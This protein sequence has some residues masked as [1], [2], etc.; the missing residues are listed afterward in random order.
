MKKVW[1]LFLRRRRLW[2]SI[3]PPLVTILTSSVT[4]G[5][6]QNGIRSSCVKLLPKPTRTARP[7][8]EKEP[9][10]RPAN[11]SPPTFTKF[12]KRN[13]IADFKSLQTDTGPSFFR[14]L[15][16]TG[17][18]V[19]A[20]ARETDGSSWSTSTSRLAMAELAFLSPTATAVQIHRA[21]ASAQ[22]AATSAFSSSMFFNA[23]KKASSKFAT[24][25]LGSL[26]LPPPLE[27]LLVRCVIGVEV[28]EVLGQ[29]PRA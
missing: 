6:V 16:C 1:S 18:A 19:A 22:A 25:A 21:N 9:P 17:V 4:V 8:S 7:P 20:A 27:I 11:A 14:E 13:K 10:A 28:A 29:C 5:N 3:R 23:I 26:V 2:T 15:R 24:G 12:F